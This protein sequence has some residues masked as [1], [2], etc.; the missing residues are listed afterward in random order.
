MKKPRERSGAYYCSLGGRCCLFAKTTYHLRVLMIRNII[1]KYIVSS[2]LF[3]YGLRCWLF[4][5]VRKLNKLP[6]FLYP[7]KLLL[8][9]KSCIVAKEGSL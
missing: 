6:T 5:N 3:S 8:I 7:K 9:K 1:N 2:H 4:I